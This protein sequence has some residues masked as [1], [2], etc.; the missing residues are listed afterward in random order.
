MVTIVLTHPNAYCDRFQV[1]GIYDSPR[2]HHTFA[3]HES[4]DRCE[5]EVIAQK[6]MELYEADHFRRVV[7]GLEN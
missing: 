3:V 6:L 5:A 2:R 4:D 1:L 7:P